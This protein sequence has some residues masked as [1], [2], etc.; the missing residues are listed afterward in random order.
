M[1]K[2]E[3]G[4]P[5][6]TPDWSVVRDR[7]WRTALALTRC[8]DQADDLTQQTLC[9]LLAG[10]PDHAEQFAYARRTMLRLWLDRQRSVRRWLRRVARWSRT[11]RRSAEDDDVLPIAED[12]ERAQRAIET[13]PARQRATIVLRLVEE[14]DYQQIAAMLDCSVQTVRANLHLARRRVRRCIGEPP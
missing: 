8:R 3:S 13:L 4:E 11:A 1:P 5:R 12:Y 2:T 6:A 7:L 10:H 9:T 14:L